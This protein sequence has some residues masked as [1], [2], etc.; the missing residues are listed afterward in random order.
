MILLRQRLFSKSNYDEF[1]QDYKDWEKQENRR[2][3]KLEKE[4]KK[5]AES[6]VPIYDKY[7]YTN[8]SNNQARYTREE[9]NDRKKLYL[10]PY[11][12]EVEKRH[13]VKMG[14]PFDYDDDEKTIKDFKKSGEKNNKLVGSLAGGSLGFLGGIAAGSL[15]T[16][17]SDKAILAGLAGA[18][19]GALVG[20][21]AGKSILGKKDEKLIK[22]A[23][24]ERRKESEIKFGKRSKA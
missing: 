12:E 18:G 14:R 23:L 15:K 1:W 20:T 5:L 10:Q 6:R 2:Q 17:N 9:D 19:I 7:L 8:L 4:K 22:E 3:K 13:G 11:V 24:E 21:K 16:K